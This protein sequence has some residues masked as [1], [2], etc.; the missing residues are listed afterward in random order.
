MAVFKR[1]DI[2]EGGGARGVVRGVHD[3]WVWVEHPPTDGPFTYVADDLTL[4]ERARTYPHRCAPG[5]CVVC[6]NRADMAAATEHQP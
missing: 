3:C 6:D 1:G 5:D 2:V 4:V